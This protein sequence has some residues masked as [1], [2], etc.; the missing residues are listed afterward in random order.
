[1]EKILAI[2]NCRVSSNEQLQNN[3][4]ARQEKSV[5]GAAARLNAEIVQVWSGSVSSKAGTNVKRKDLLDMLEACKKT[6]FIKYAIFDEYDRFMRS[7]NEGPYFEVLFQQAG[8][9]VWYASES[10]AFNGDDAMAKFMRTMSAYKAEGS[11]EERQR[12]S[13]NGQTA[14]LR[15]GRY[16][17]HPKAGYKKGKISGIHEVHPVRGRELQK[18]LKRMY[19]G[20][21]GPTDAL[22]EFNKSDFTKDHA[23]YKMDK[24][25]K[26]ATDIYYAGYLE[27]NKQ[28]KVSGVK[29][30][31]EP[32]ITLEEHYRLVE[33]FDKK[34][35]Y[36]IG[37]KR[38]GNPMFPLNNLVED[39]GCV[40]LKNKGRLV[41]FVHTNGRYKKT[42]EKYRCRSC[43]HYWHREEMHD[44]IIDLFHRYEMSPETQKSIIA[45]LETVWQKDSEN[46]ISEERT[47]RRSIVEL[48][49]YIEEKVESAI[50]DKNKDIK[51]DILK[52][53]E[54]KKKEL[55]TLKSQLIKL[56]KEES[57]DKREF[58][59][60]A[61]SFIQDTGQHFLE[62]TVSKERRLMCKQMLFPAGIFID[63]KNKVYT[64]E[65]SVF[66]RLATN[67]KDL[68]ELEKSSMVRVRRL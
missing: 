17:F 31:H 40:E 46:K 12:K 29:G 27:M 39:V 54:K 28:V 2:A 53:I 5:Y 15:D 34:P 51:N 32:L 21:V 25:R 13:I 35:K 6:K 67:K 43:G 44:K 59:E 9:K 45:A 63:E 7:V 52:I 50:D 57:D 48:E 18:I 4:L 26:I 61:L 33:I 55:S 65:I 42:Y 14:A 36:Q 58:M 47:M 11:N 49:R 10:D 60:F 20:F 8:V 56:I 37:P 19:A 68:S 22:I 41:G 30:L 66:Y 24:F 23:P 62:P 16:T 64:P 1:M 38:K 3:S